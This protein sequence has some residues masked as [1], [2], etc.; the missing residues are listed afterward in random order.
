MKKQD[1]PPGLQVRKERNLGSLRVPGVLEEISFA[2]SNL[3]Q[4]SG[5]AIGLNR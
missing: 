4:P 5:G 1:F 3:S 2:A